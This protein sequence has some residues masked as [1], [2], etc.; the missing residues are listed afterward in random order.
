MSSAIKVL[1]NILELESF[2][3]ERLQPQNTQTDP[4]V[5]ALFFLYDVNPMNPT[6]QELQNL[7]KKVA[8]ANNVDLESIIKKIK[9]GDIRY[10]VTFDMGCGG[11]SAAYYRF[12]DGQDGGN[13]LHQDGGNDLH[14]IDWTYDDI[15]ITQSGHKT[16]SVTDIGI[17]TII[18]FSSNN[19]NV[20][21]GPNG[22]NLR[23]AQNFKNLPT[24]QNLS[25]TVIP[26]HIFNGQVLAVSL[27]LRDVWQKYFHE[28]VRTIRENLVSNK[29]P[30]EGSNFIFAV[31]HPASKRWKE[32][33]PVYRC[34]IAEATGLTGEQILTISEAKAAMQYVN[35]HVNKVKSIKLK[36]GVIIFD[37]GAS[38]FDIEALTLDHPEGIEC[39][40]TM[41]GRELDNLLLNYLLVQN[42]GPNIKFDAQ[43]FQ[44]HI[45][46]FGTEASFR[47][48]IRKLKED[49]FNNLQADPGYTFNYQFQNG[50]TVP[51]DGQ[52]IKNLVENRLI[53]V[54]V[55]SEFIQYLNDD[56]NNRFALK[57]KGNTVTGSWAQ[58][59]TSFVTFAM[60]LFGDNECKIGKAIITGGSARISGISDYITLGIQ[61]SKYCQTNFNAL[62]D[63]DNIQ[64]LNGAAAYE[65]TV[66]FGTIDYFK[67]VVNSAQEL[68]AFEG[69]LPELLEKDIRADVGKYVAD[70]LVKATV[71]DCKQT[72]QTWANFGAAN[73]N[74]SINWL[75]NAI[76][77][78]LRKYF[79]SK[80]IK[81]L[82]KAAAAEVEYKTTK[83]S[84]KAL[85]D[86]M[87]RVEYNRGISI[88]LKLTINEPNVDV[89]DLTKIVNN[90]CNDMTNTITGMVAALVQW[91][92][93]AFTGNK[94]IAPGARE[95]VRDD[96]TKKDCA[97]LKKLIRNSIDV[98]RILANIQFDKE[99]ESKRIIE[100]MAADIQRALFIPQ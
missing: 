97:K 80:K 59:F 65:Q 22:I 94:T 91:V 71:N 36:N 43:F 2:D 5:K 72:L 60:D 69:K 64:L 30:I 47:Y 18:G 25:G 58:I 3:L 11:T 41:A 6:A 95:K 33:L 38:T 63:A 32:F 70:E 83:E 51:I 93:N 14:M 48:Q 92:V 49:L 31:A 62:I 26:A 35:C 27:N 28:T 42:Y 61:N 82:C 13:D 8:A 1:E 78:T 52:V 55:E 40:L 21:I 57:I 4:V 10:L 24:A 39:S 100:E 44:Q 99:E 84:I 68:I 46:D 81:Q 79:T 29:I 19:L 16:Q 20:C 23:P 90:I 77:G 96:L 54:N 50:N 89:N 98:N 7:K 86:N 17:P 85:L 66:P 67:P 56:N 74:G 34:M 73:P 9:E 76:K 53:T 75:E 15:A 12:D 88:A 87:A 37:I 45:N